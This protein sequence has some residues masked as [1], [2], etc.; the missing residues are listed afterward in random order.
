MVREQPE[1]RSACGFLA[2]PLPSLRSSSTF[3]LLFLTLLFSL[4]LSLCA[5]VPLPPFFLFLLFSA[6]ASGR[7]TDAKEKQIVTGGIGRFLFTPLYP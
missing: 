5:F 3:L 6:S 1:S 4:S 7:E 2:T